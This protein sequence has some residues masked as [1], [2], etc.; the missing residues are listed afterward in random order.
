MIT[1]HDTGEDLVVKKRVAKERERKTAEMVYSQMSIQLTTSEMWPG[2]KV[3]S[4]P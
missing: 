2:G 1:M 3:N 4:G